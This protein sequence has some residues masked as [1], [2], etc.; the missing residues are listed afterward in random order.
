[1]KKSKGKKKARIPPPP[2]PPPMMESNMESNS[3]FE[4]DLDLMEAPRAKKVAFKNV[5][6]YMNLCS[7]IAVILYLFS[8]SVSTE[9]KWSEFGLNN[10]IQYSM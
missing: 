2:P 6:V 5:Q 1:M 3:N 8:P 10:F 4:Q 7:T 9:F